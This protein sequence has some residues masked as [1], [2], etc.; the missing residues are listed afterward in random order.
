MGQY[1]IKVENLSKQYRLGT[2][3]TGTLSHDLNRFWARLRGKEDPYLEIGDVNQRDKSGESDF[4]WAL[5]DIDFKVPEGEVLGIIGRNG[6]GKSTL[7]KILSQVTSPTLGRIS[8]RGRVGSLLEVGT[9]FHPELTGRENIFLNGAIL[10]MKKWEIRSKLDE[11]VDFS[12]C[13]RYLDT[14]VKRYSSGMI[15]RLGF[16][17]AAHLEPEILIVDEVLAVGDAEFQKKCVGKMQSISHSEGRTIIFVS[18]NLPVVEELCTQSIVLKNG[19]LDYSG[20]VYEG[21]KHYLEFGSEYKMRLGSQLKLPICHSKLELQ[22]IFV[23]S[24]DHRV[25]E[26]QKTKI[27][28]TLL[29]KDTINYDLKRFHIDIGISD[30]TAMRIAWISTKVFGVEGAS[31]IFEVNKL[32]EF[33]FDIDC[34]NLIPGQYS[35]TVFISYGGET[36]FWEKEFYQF[37]VYSERSTKL[38]SIPKNQ[39]HI[40]LNGTVTCK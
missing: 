30:C 11:I 27:V 19:I 18:H 10:G 29:N 4:V 33:C 6:A 8:M 40:L 35:L 2:I 17:V 32:Q 14:P 31:E 39:G 3:G 28:L 22:N 36:L 21:I 7:L 1:A 12:G 34:L 5:K 37:S 16:A 15:V 20:D 9:G 24:E 13:E 23:G 25:L 26:S 38:N